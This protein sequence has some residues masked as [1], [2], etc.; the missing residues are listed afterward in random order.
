M[1]N[2]PVFRTRD[3]TKT[4]IMGEVIIHALRGVDMELYPGELVVLLGASG[5]GKSTLLNI[6]GGLDA[7][8][9]G[10][11]RYRE[12]YLTG[13]TDRVL[14]EFRRH[15][16]GFV[17]QFYN[18][19]PSLTARENVAISGWLQRVELEPGDEVAA[20]QTLFSLE[21]PP[22][23]SLDERS[24]K[25]AQELLAAVKARREAA[26][27][28]KEDR[29]SQVSFARVEYERQQRL[30]DRG[31]ASPTALDAARNELERQQYALRMAQAAHEASH[32]E[33]ENARAV[34]DV[35][36]GS[37]DS[38]EARMLH[39]QSPASGVVLQRERSREGVISAGEM[40][41]EIGNLQELEVQVDLLS[42]DA[43]RVQPGME[44]IL[45][46]WGGEENLQGTVRRLK[47]AGFKRV[48]A[49]GV[50][51]QRVPVMVQI[52]SPR[53]EWQSLG[54]GYRVEARFILWEGSDVVQI[55]TSALFREDDA[56][57]VF[58]VENGQARQQ[59]IEIGRRSGLRTQI[60]AG[61]EPGEQ[62]ITHPGDHLSD[63][64]RVAHD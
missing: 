59:S 61:L 48:S 32:F 54:A 26:R 14:T 37:R 8:T 3:L 56:W 47:P 33:V 53:E 29:Q 18:L 22:T 40:V 2:T 34:L 5:S 55:P 13:A 24:R 35:L 16:V 46:R 30:Y 38:D 45:E 4:Y 9:S 51:E 39:I 28:E 43:V 50:D 23:P 12:Q 41:L 62:V 52:T 31:I 49:L 25:Q 60:T 27:V 57:Q 10:E 11:V 63:G 36:Q 17:F 6:L 15:H 20:G 44:V 19:I 42:M 1:E 64:S 7:A 58:V 21:P